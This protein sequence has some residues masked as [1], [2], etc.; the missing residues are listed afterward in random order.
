[1]QAQYTSAEM[2]RILITAKDTVQATVYAPAVA[3]KAVLVVHSATATPQ[4]FYRAFAQHAAANGLVAIT[5]DYRGTGRSGPPKQ[6]SRF[7]MRDWIQQDAPAVAHWAK[8]RYPDLPHYAIGHSLGGHALVL[9]FG[10]EHLDAAAIISSHVVS[11]RTIKPWQE[12]LRVIMVL[13]VLGPVLSTIFGY[14]PGTKLGLG[15]DMPRAAM[16]EW[17]GWALKKNYFFDDPSM[18][19]AQRAARTTVPILAAGASDD[20]WASPRQ[21]DLLT[22][23]LS[24]AKVERKTYTPAG[25]SVKSIGHH[26]LMRRG[27][28]TGAWDEILAWLQDASQKAQ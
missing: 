9:G 7:K 12:R 24:A 2:V 13:K 25:L 1:M 18:N 5:Y 10:T 22:A 27:V 16:M 26:G 28:G 17:S 11:I 20:L 15:E 23:Q 4:G 8:D 14:M 3:P 19:A 21:M 6:N